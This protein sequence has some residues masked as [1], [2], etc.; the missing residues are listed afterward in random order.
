MVPY[1]SDQF[2]DKT[3]AAGKHEWIYVKGENTVESIEVEIDNDAELVYDLT[4]PFEA[5]CRER[6]DGLVNIFVPHATAGVA[7]MEVGSGSDT[8]LA[9]AIDVILPTDR[10][11]R[12]RHGSQGHGRDHLL[13]CFISPSLT[14]PIRD[15]QPLLGVWQRLVLIDTNRDNPHRRVRF[16]VLSG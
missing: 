7:L 3:S 14:V 13:P 6:G 12:H 11:Y 16:S 2:H 5:F 15:G 8:D 10:P 1:C 4:V 9:A